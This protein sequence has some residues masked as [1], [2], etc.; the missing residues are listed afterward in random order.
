M[1][2]RVYDLF[3]EDILKQSAE[4]YMI[5]PNKLKMLDG[6]E[7]FIYLFDKDSKEYILRIT[8]AERRTVAMIEAEMEWIQYLHNHGVNCSLPMISEN[9]TLAEIVGED[10]KQFI[11]CA[12]DKCP[13]VR[14]S[15]DN[16]SNTFY[17]NYGKLIGRMHSLTK[18]YKPTKPSRIHWFDD[19]LLLK[20]ESILPN[21]HELLKER[22][23]ENINLIKSMEKHEDN[24]G[25][26]H[27]DAHAGNFLIDDEELYIF[28]FDDS[29][30]AYFSADIAIILFYFYMHCPADIDQT[31]FI[32]HFFEHFMKGYN[33]ENTIAHQEL[34]KIPVFLKQ[35][36]FML[37]L[38]IIQAY[39]FDKYDA[40]ATKYMNG[41]KAKLENNTPYLNL[42][43]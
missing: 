13:G 18:S 34:E 19:E 31:K 8:H 10:D 23:L 32:N 25:L 14:L 42:N 37:Y 6:F 36:E 17:Y 27:F 9:N 24:Y 41:R 39:G 28:D 43:L 22:L 33:S 38:A 16:S 7:S 40:W 26:V 5:D 11:V 30:Y 29:Q 2:K 21:N 15:R 3:N 35:R 1:E 20:Y 4:K 12:F